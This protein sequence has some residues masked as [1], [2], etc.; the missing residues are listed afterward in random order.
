MEPTPE[1][2]SDQHT[3]E[4]AGDGATNEAL[5]E[6]AERTER[7]TAVPEV[8][9]KGDAFLESQRGVG[10]TMLHHILHLPERRSEYGGNTTERLQ[11]VG[12]KT[13][14]VVLGAFA[15]KLGISGDQVPMMA[16]TVVA[17]GS[18][19]A[20]ATSILHGM[21]SDRET[22]DLRRSAAQARQADSGS[23]S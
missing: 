9:A 10:E 2:T 14:S 23:A 18:V 5:R 13:L 7:E 17:G 16:E 12:L 6:I 11:S 4:S 15:I 20:L 3:P 21:V 22:R 8:I 19:V 1:L